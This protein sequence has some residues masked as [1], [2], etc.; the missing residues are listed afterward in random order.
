MIA[1]AKINKKHACAAQKINTELLHTT[2]KIQ[3]NFM[4]AAAKTG[5]KNFTK[6]IH[7]Y[8]EKGHRG[9]LFSLIL[10]S[11]RSALFPPPGG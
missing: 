10:A 9:E 8:Q 7:F 4:V 3:T 1:Q 2:S 11:A 5:K 6:R